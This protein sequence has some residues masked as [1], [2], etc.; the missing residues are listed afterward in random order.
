MRITPII[1]IGIGV[2][3]VMAPDN[4]SN[5]DV[6]NG[7]FLAIIIILLGIFALWRSLRR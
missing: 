3:G 1:L 2:W 5:L 4:L 7:R 6:N